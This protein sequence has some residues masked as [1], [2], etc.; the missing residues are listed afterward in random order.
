MRLWQLSNFIILHPEYEFARGTRFQLVAPIFP[1]QWAHYL[2]IACIGD[3]P[4]DSH[5]RPSEDLA[6]CF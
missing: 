1:T 4:E 3:T 5:V 6:A 2:E